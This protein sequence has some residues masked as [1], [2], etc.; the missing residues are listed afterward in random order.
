ML[1]RALSLPYGD[2]APLLASLVLARSE[3][4]GGDSRQIVDAAGYHRVVGYAIEAMEHGR[5]AHETTAWHEL[6]ARRMSETAQANLLRTELVQVRPVLEA[7]CDAPPILVKGPA[8]ADRF[9][10]P[11]RLRPFRDLDLLV[12][13]AR[14]DAAVGA[15]E[16]T[17]GYR[18]APEPWPGYGERQGHHVALTRKVGARPVWVELHWRLSDDPVARGL[19]H[20]RLLAG[21]QPLELIEGSIPVPSVA[22]Q[23]LVLAVHLVQENRKRLAWINDLALVSRAASEPQ[24][25]AAFDGA[26]A[27]LELGAPPCPG[28]RAP[29]ARTGSPAADGTR[30]A[31]G[32]GPA[33]RQ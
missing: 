7:A 24:W 4:S 9:Y 32:V 13:P 17:L 18:R 3:P 23:L 20:A 22:D 11:A 2:Q 5:L 16:Q 15:L 30:S 26:G 31:S 8:V 27:R 28:L 33:A 19:D 21:S 29:L 12:P 10:H 25:R 6:L 1:R 14:L